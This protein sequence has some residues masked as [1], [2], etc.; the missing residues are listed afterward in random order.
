MPLRINGLRYRPRGIKQ[1][2]RRRR[3]MR[4]NLKATRRPTTLTK[5]AQ[6]EWIALH[7]LTLELRHPHRPHVR[8]S[9]LHWW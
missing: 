2:R 5:L 7:V 8:V 4:K 3:S 1:V 9:Q 6:L